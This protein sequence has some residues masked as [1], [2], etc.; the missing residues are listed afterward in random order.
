MNTRKKLLPL[1][2]LISMNC[3]G[4]DWE[5]FDKPNLCRLEVPR[6]WLVKPYI[7]SYN[8]IISFYPD[9]NHFWKLKNER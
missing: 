8:V 6:G 5:C 1:I 9:E 4:L 2:L 3:Y 7:G